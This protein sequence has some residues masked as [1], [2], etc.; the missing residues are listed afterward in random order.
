MYLTINLFFIVNILKLK[1][2]TQALN[3][4]TKKIKLIIQHFCAE[5]A[6]VLR[7]IQKYT[8]VCEVGL[9]CINISGQWD[10]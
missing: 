7:Y 4:E 6:K 5:L 2:K 8:K 9:L 1:K 3:Q 10:C